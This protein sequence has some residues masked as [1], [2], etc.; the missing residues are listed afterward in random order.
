MP[1]WSCW[2]HDRDGGR[3]ADFDLLYPVRA[4]AMGVALWSFRACI[5]GCLEVVLA[6]N[7]AR[8]CRLYG[9]DAS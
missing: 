9:M 8:E 3:F 5:A 6:G 1:W 2:N 4:S 7:R